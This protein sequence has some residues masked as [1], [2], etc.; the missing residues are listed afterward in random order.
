MDT[1]VA[2][3]QKIVSYQGLDKLE[4]LLSV[5]SAL[6][7]AFDCPWIILNI[8]EGLN[9]QIKKLE[10]FS[11][12]DC[13]ELN[14]KNLKKI[15]CNFLELHLLPKNKKIKILSLIEN[16]IYNDNDQ[17][18]IIFDFLKINPFLNDDLY[19]F[20]LSNEDHIDKSI[21]KKYKNRNES[22][23]FLREKHISF[24]YHQNCYDIAKRQK[25]I[26][27][28]KTTWHRIELYNDKASFIENLL[29]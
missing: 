17:S 24:K 25:I 22:S 10:S 7:D 27:M 1:F 8:N 14:E 29:I 12:F 21:L 28:W 20:I 13:R 16:I 9:D 23:K 2:I 5:K 11:F 19:N 18:Y 4:I 26:Q 3:N 6:I 15:S